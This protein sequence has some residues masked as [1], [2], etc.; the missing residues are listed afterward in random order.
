LCLGKTTNS[1]VQFPTV[2]VQSSFTPSP[3]HT[4]PRY[5]STFPPTHS[6]VLSPILAVVSIC[7]IVS[8]Q[9]PITSPSPFILKNV[10]LWP[11]ISYTSNL[12]FSLLQSSACPIVST[13]YPSLNNSAHLASFFGT[14]RLFCDYFYKIITQNVL[15][16]LMINSLPFLG[17]DMECYQLLVNLI[18]ESNRRGN[19]GAVQLWIVERNERMA[20]NRTGCELKR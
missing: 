2:R 19:E 8:H 1:Q 9:H 4:F 15:K 20:S 18:E 11:E 5:F 12:V 7:P 17:C 14:F 3:S 16:L 13:F 6:T 10:P